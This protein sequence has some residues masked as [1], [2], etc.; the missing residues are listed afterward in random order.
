MTR[1]LLR[2]A[3]L[4]DVAAI[5][6]IKQRLRLE[7]A[8]EPTRGGFLLGCSAERYAALV[9]AANVL[10]LEVGG[11]PA[12]FAITLPDPVLRASELWSR[13]DH[14]LWKPGEAAPPEGDAVAYFDQLAVSPDAPR[15]HVAALA[16]AAVRTLADT[17]HRHLYATTLRA[18]VTNRA[19]FP[20]LD[21]L[22]ARRVGE[23][24]ELYADVGP[25]VSDLHHSVLPAD[26]DR[27]NRGAGGRRLRSYA[28]A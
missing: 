21:A 16:F 26:F 14:I 25:V 12:G 8:Q 6:A 9:A 10:M 20:L 18:P 4:C 11:E 22:G 28:V 24:E 19:A 23:V 1:P 7:P 17:G 2:R 27:V 3:A 13:R 5:V 15:L